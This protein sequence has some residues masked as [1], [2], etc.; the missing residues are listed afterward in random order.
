MRVCIASSGLGHVQRG[1]ES[2]ARDLAEALRSH[3][4]SVE[5][6]GADPGGIENMTILPA[7]KRTTALARRIGRTLRWLGAWRLGISNSYDIEQITF[8]FALW[9]RV[10]RNFDIVHVQD[11]W[12][13]KILDVAWRLG[14]SRP[15]VVFANGIGIGVDTLARLTY[16]QQLSPAGQTATG[17]PRARNRGEWMIPNFI[18]TSE[19][20]P[21]DRRRAR[22]RLGLPQD[23]F[24]VL[25]CAAIRQHHKRVDHLVREFAT[26]TAN[27]MRDAVLV[28][29]GAR[30]PDTEPVL[31]LGRELLGDRVRFLIDL[32][33]SSMPELYQAAD[34]F[35]LCSLFETFGIVLIEAMASGLPVIC[36][37]APIFRF[38]CGSAG[39]FCDM[40]RQ[41]ELAGALGAAFADRDLPARGTAARTHVLATFAEDVV[42]PRIVKMY[43]EV[44]GA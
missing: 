7:L 21:G 6:F 35:T 17:A 10:R 20:R 8:A 43:T 31:A 15:R 30:E 26:A 29:A 11:Y 4:Q 16:L 1:I 13:A 18:N 27:G 41:G 22:E 5:L 19:Y 12:L 40:E 23:A 37:D 25:C 34:I 9:L 3:G 2:W 28:I 39:T 44:L 36:H 42:V 33:R 38:V 14:L 24:V 32:P